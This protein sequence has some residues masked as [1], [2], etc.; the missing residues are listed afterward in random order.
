MPELSNLLKDRLSRAGRPEVHPDADLLTAYAEK[1]LPATERTQVMEHLSW[2]SQCRDVVF[3]TMEPAAEEA[4]VIAVV[5]ARR[6]RWFLTPQFGMLA[7]VCA[8]AVG[9]GLVVRVQTANQNASE[10]SRV[11][12]AK[13]AQ[14]GVSAGVLGQEPGAG[15]SRAKDSEIEIRDSKAAGAATSGSAQTASAGKKPERAVS[16]MPQVASIAPARSDYVN[17]QLFATASDA[18]F[19]NTNGSGDLPSAP[20]PAPAANTLTQ[21]KILTREQSITLADL[22]G[23]AGKQNQN[24]LTLYQPRAGRQSASFADKLV[25]L[26]RHVHAK[27]LGPAISQ[28]A[29]RSFA[30]A[31]PLPANNALDAADALAAKP[32]AKSESPGLKE[33]SAFSANG[34]RGRSNDQDM[35]SPQWKVDHGKLLK[36]ED[37]RG[38]VEMAGTAGLEF[39][40][41]TSSGAEVWAGGSHAALIYSNDAGATW[42]KITLG[43]SASG[44][45][46]SIVMNG[47]SV[48]VKTSANQTWS[49]QD[50]GKSWQVK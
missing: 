36:F 6:R 30:M 14:P 19:Q 44:T 28:D 12:E 1:A 15:D 9:I 46:V 35:G 45:V 42:E 4:A 34:L 7:A 32:S 13:A 33:S 38:Y 41:V 26:G 10:K 27:R 40:V 11:Q 43:D 50:D 23:D 47:S 29:A 39:S 5:P 24:V 25:D 2:C 16:N 20:A 18:S 8:M 21:A 37:G 31:T 48:T 3:L 49:S 17:L 22:P